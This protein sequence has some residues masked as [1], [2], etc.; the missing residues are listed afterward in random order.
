MERAFVILLILARI[1]LHTSQGFEYDIK[2]SVLET[3]GE[4]LAS[5]LSTVC[6]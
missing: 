2:M 5:K 4:Q 3:Q 6:P 1:C